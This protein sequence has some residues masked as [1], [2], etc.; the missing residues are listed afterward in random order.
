V[1]VRESQ[2][3]LGVGVG[4]LSGISA[5]LI[6]AS[7]ADDVLRTLEPELSY[8]RLKSGETLFTAGEPGDALYVVV[9]GRLRALLRGDSDDHQVFGEIGRGESV[10]EMAV[11]TGEPRSATVYAIRDTALVRLSK[12]SFERVIVNHPRAMLEMTRLIVTRYRRIINPSSQLQPVA[13][14]VVPCHAAIPAADFTAG[15]IRALSPGRK[16]LLLDAASVPQR[17]PT[18][19]HVPRDVEESDL[20]GWLHDQEL[21]H[22]FVI[23]LADPEPS[24]WTRLCMRQADLVL[25]VAGGAAAT[26][27]AGLETIGGGA[28]PGARR[29]LVLLTNGGAPSGTADWLARVS[30][31]AHHHLDLRVPHHY[32]RLARM[33]TGRAIG[34]VLG[35]GGARALAHIGVIRA[36]EE[37]GIPIDLVGG[38]SSGAIVGGQYASGWESARILE[39]SRRVLIEQGSLNDF[40]LPVIALLRGKRQLRMLQALFGDRRIEDLPVSYFCIST[41]L[42]RST[43]M[44]HRTGG[45]ANGVAASCA[46]PGLTPPRAYGRDILVDGGV[47]NNLPVNIMRASGRG[48]VFASSVSPGA[49]LSL[50]QEYPDSPSPWRLVASWLNPWG[51]PMLIPS[52]ASILMRTYSLQES[53]PGAP[54]DLVVESPADSYKLRDWHALNEIAEIGYRAAVPAIEQ[55]QRQQLA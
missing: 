34:L 30:V 16:V 51:T 20:A 36:L 28:A 8:V 9:Y 40:T 49:D 32:D 45:L 31:S 38:T 27:Q 26:L 41:N 6:F 39:E 22:D 7:L 17:Q 44:V 13:I 35:G 33:L 2:P 48:P 5:S 21:Q 19:D 25:F 52:I 29:E 53:L 11:L 18:T 50:D 10:G 37:A 14:A 3:P 12:A 43:C 42:T 54:A 23:Y 55:W 47:L 24:S 15:L 4:N 46:V 1:D